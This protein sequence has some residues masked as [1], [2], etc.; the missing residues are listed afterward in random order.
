LCL[1]DDAPDK[2]RWVHIS[3]GEQAEKGARAWAGGNH[4]DSAL[5][6]GDSSLHK[7]SSDF[8]KVRFVCLIK[9]DRPSFGD[10]SR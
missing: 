6:A 3:R 2:A 7:L 4:S 1:R 5:R 10:R 8:L 9:I